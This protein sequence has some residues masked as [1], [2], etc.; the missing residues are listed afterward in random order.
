MNY[1]YELPKNWVWVK[2]GDIV[3]NHGQKKPDKEFTYIELSSVDNKKNKIA[4]FNVLQPNNAPS[5]ARKIVHRGDVLYGTVRTYL[6]NI[7]MIESDITPEPLASAAFSVMSTGNTVSNKYLF[8]FLLSPD[9]D[10]YSNENSTGTMYPSIKEKKLLQALIPL[11]PLP[12]QQRIVK[13]LESLFSKLDEARQKVQFALDGFDR[14]RAAIL[15]RA[16]TGEL[17]RNFRAENHIIDKWRNVKLEDI[18]QVT[19]GGTPSTLNHEYW[20]GGDISWVTPAD[21]RSLK[22]KYISRGAKN[23]TAKGLQSSSARIMPKGSIV[24]SSRAPIG[25]VAIAANDLCTSQGC[26]SLVPF[27][28]A[29]PEYI[30]FALLYRNNDIKEMGH[31]T[32]FKEIS[33]KIF[34]SVVI[35]LPP[36]EEQREI[37]RILD[38]L[39]TKEQQAK[40]L[41]QSV[42][43]KVDTLKKSILAR[44]FRGQLGTNNPHDEPSVGLL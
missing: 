43:R 31:G 24:F 36:L 25:Y 26:K 35:P 30:Y 4:E 41:A 10:T 1:P 17:T 28:T 16:F 38:S 15:H 9:F 11:A 7:C 20:D 39:L 40:Q 29:L 2:L 34:G 32:T 33:G 6:H 21:M 19:G 8:F 18:G 12:E 22:S 13:R 37:A 44:A 14:R 23:I 42:I 3:S 27:E 5:S